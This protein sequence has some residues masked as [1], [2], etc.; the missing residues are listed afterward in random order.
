MFSNI[1]ISNFS[2]PIMIENVSRFDI[3]M[4]DV[5]FMKFIESF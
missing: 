2:Y 4:D 1:Q 5:R 3:P